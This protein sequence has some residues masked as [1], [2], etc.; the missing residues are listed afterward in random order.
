MMPLAPPAAHA[1]ILAVVVASS[2]AAVPREQ[3][4][5]A[6]AAE[7]A[8]WTAIRAGRPEDAAT[9]FREAV[10]LGPRRAEPLL[11]IGLAE[12]LL[13]HLD[14]A[15]QALESALQLDPAQTE[16][17][18]LLGYVLYRKGDVDGAIQVYEQALTRA[19]ED[20]MIGSRLESLRHEADVHGRFSQRLGDHFTVLFEGPAE[21][22]LAARTV[23]LLEAA[24]WRIGTALGAFPNELITVVLYTQEQFRDITRSPSWAAGAFDG[25]IRVPM[26]GALKNPQ[27]L[28]QVLSHEFTHAL[29]YSVA[30]RGVPQWLNEGLALLFEPGRVAALETPGA[31]GPANAEA[32]PL[33]RLENSFRELSNADARRAYL[34]SAEAVQVL[35]AQSGLPAVLNLLQ[36]VGTGMRFADAFERSIGMRY[37]DFQRALPPPR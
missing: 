22:A 10:R 6:A 29:V 32:V 37:E 8:G 20:A 7:K 26:R 30:P 34:E 36:N 21:E 27:E 13:G 18:R 11:G 2:S 19:P 33:S 16:A 1:L 15:R 31:A 4:R 25:R 24:Y 23:D 17:S 12:F 14:G 9:A 3:E 5:T 28:D 35:V